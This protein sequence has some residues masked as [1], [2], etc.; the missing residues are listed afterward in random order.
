M[1][2]KVFTL[3][4][5]LLPRDAHRAARMLA[6][7]AAAP[8]PEE[9][10]GKLE[11]V[12]TPAVRATLVTRSVITPILGG[13]PALFGA[14][15]AVLADFLRVQS[16]RLN[17][18]RECLERMAAAI[19]EV[20][21]GFSVEMPSNWPLLDLCMPHL[22]ALMERAES[23]ATLYLPVIRGQL[24]RAMLLERRRAHAEALEVYSSVVKLARDSLGPETDLTI[25]SMIGVAKASTAL[26]NYAAAAETLEEAA[27]RSRRGLGDDHPF[28]YLAS[29]N[30]AGALLH[31][32]ETERARALAEETLAAAER[33]L[34]NEDLMTASFREQLAEVM[35]AQ[36]N[37]LGGLNLSNEVFRVRVSQLGADHPQTLAS[38][39]TL[40][41]LA[42]EVGQYETARMAQDR[43]L[44]AT[45]RQFGRDHPRTISAMNA[46]AGT[47]RAQGEL[48]EA[49]KLAQDVVSVL[50]AGAEEEVPF[51]LAQQTMA[52]ID[53]AE[54]KYTDAETKLEGL[55][56]VAQRV[57]GPQDGITLTLIGS[58]AGVFHERG[59]YDKARVLQEDVLRTWREKTSTNHPQKLRAMSNLAGTLAAMGD[60]DQARRLREEITEAVRSAS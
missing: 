11:A 1:F 36:G 37:L 57:L 21:I 39:Q 59:H 53:L 38:I 18:T 32:G 9:V 56:D 5:E 23:W 60:V 25:V 29:S 54:G 26:G 34:G 44:K 10:V 16:E 55:I 8:V 40:G 46:L 30:L 12:F 28:T 14:M 47:L 58:L 15:H 17:D 13:T 24:D 3:A 2:Q 48:Q 22:E 19:H 49:R 50:G 27:E 52:L 33:T 51:L 43:L 7:G 42:D 35:I 31:L 20:C 4:Y 41:D 45:E 6:H